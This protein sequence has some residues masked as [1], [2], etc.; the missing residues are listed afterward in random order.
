MTP[1]VRRLVQQVVRLPGRERVARDRIEVGAV[2]ETGC[3]AKAERRIVLQRELRDRELVMHAH[4]GARVPRLPVQ[5]C[6]DTGSRGCER[7]EG[8]GERNQV[9]ARHQGGS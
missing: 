5:R 8:A 2:V 9:A 4:E 7:R 3:G 1:V 6:D